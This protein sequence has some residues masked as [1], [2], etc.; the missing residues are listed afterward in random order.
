MNKLFASA[1]LAAVS[2]AAGDGKCRA[3]VMS[4]GSNNGAWEAGVFWG[5]V[6]Y[7]NPADYTY[8][9]VSGV[10]AGSI[11]TGAF[12]TWEKGTE[13][14]LSEWLSDQW[15]SMTNDQLYT[16]RSLNPIKDLFHE[17][18][19]FDDDPAIATLTRIYSYTGGEIKRHFAVSAVD[20]NTGDYNAMT[21]KNTSFEDLPRSVMSSAS[22]PVVFPALSLNGKVNMD[23]GTVWNTNLDSAIEQCLEIVDDPKDIIVDVAICG[24]SHLP[25]L[26]VKKN[27][28]EDFLEAKSIRDYYHS[29]SGI[30][31]QAAAY[32]GLDI[33]YYFQERTSCP[34]SGGLDFNNSTTWCLQEQGRT[35]AKAMLDIGSENVRDTLAEWRADKKL[36][37]EYPYFK[38]YLNAIYNTV[39]SQ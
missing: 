4:G 35:D 30:W 1:I 37:K 2:Q 21:D 9:T 10:S 22:I 39:F 15:A 14:E 16:L 20:A 36:I 13:V 25:E 38:D 34:G 26:E 24:Y 33:R 6:H 18:S 17:P 11:N 12:A 19:A 8:D 28:L 31:E 29:T 32:P 5:L 7:G 27:A 3:L 23:G